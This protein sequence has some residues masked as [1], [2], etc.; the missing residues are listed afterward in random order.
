MAALQEI[1][2][3]LIIY[4]DD[5]LVMAETESLFEDHVKAVVYLQENLGFV[6]NHPKSE[7]DPSQ[8]ESHIDMHGLWLPPLLPACYKE[9][10]SAKGG[11][12][13]YGTRCPP[14]LLQEKTCRNR[15]T[16]WLH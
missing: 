1:G 5:I 6:I 15:S 4:I 10:Q 9:G 8:D 11:K 14:F 16:G 13:F 2:L 12:L 7:L 3:R